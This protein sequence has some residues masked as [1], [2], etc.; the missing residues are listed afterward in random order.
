MPIIHAS[1]EQ[2]TLIVGYTSG[3]D[4]ATLGNDS[5]HEGVPIS[6]TAPLLIV[7]KVLTGMMAFPNRPNQLLGRKCGPGTYWDELESPAFPSTCEDDLDG[8]GVIGVVT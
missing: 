5:L 3:V 2:Q 6:W 4:F 8:D 1:T 7:I